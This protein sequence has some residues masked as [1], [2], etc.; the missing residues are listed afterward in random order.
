VPLVGLWSNLHGGVL[1][2]AAIAAIYLVCARAGREPLVAA[3]VGA[4]MAQA[5]F[6]TP[7]LLE[8]GAY[9]RGV[10]GSR[11]ATHGE[12][13]WRP[14]SLHAPF[15]VVFLAVAVP[16]VFLAVR[17]RPLLW[18][19]VAVMALTVAAA[20]SSRNEVW[21][22]LFVAVPAARGLAGSRAWRSA[23]P[24]V[25]A[26]AVSGLLVLVAVAGL[27]RAPATA[28][29]S[30][31]LLR[32]A[33]RAAAGRPI[34][35]DALDAEQ[36][37]LAGSRILIGDPLDAFPLREQ[38]RYLDWL[39][40]RPAGDAEVSRVGVVLVPVGSTAQRR[41]SLRAH[42]AELM[43]DGL[44]VLYVRRSRHASDTDT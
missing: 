38:Q 31:R 7:A 17:S 19:T 22:V 35:A 9:Y 28:G 33:V 23:V 21:L 30:P 4:G 10:L 29:A 18:E 12:G 32:A 43:R 1:L 26:S 36:L 15:D 42:F 34:L 8:T 3:G 37:A 5:L 24:P 16:L 13:M 25:A 27:A 2:G 44:T 20:R 39:S 41:L 14:L 6:A 40:G 11:A